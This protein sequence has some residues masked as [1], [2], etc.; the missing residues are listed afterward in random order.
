V[1]AIDTN[2][3]LRRLLQDDPEQSKQANRL[4]EQEERILITDVV[5]AETIWTLKG[6]KYGID[7]TGIVSVITSLL[8]EP[9]VIFE[10]TQA[11]WGALNDYIEADRV[12]FIDALIVNKAKE[13]AKLHSE[14][15]KAVYTFNRGALK[16]PGAK[17][18]K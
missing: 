3:L 9:D 7:K 13:T 15:L 12:D 2:V 1:I 18:P 6:K 14:I 4:F 10:N 17:S 16:L 8:E 11:V 5:L